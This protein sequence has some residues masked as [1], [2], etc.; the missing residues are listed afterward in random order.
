MADTSLAWAP[1]SPARSQ[2]PLLGG[3]GNVPSH[4][5]SARVAWNPARR[6]SGDGRHGHPSDV[7]RRIPRTGSGEP[8]L[9]GESEARA[10]SHDRQGG[11]LHQ[12]HLDLY[13]HDF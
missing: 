9:F 4:G 1:Q 10:R 3:E 5:G 8:R 6:M 2:I 13:H 7:R 11:D 12:G